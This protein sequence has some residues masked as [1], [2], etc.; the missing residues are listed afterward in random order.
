MT[1]MKRFTFFLAI[2]LVLFALA[3]RVSAADADAVG[4]RLALVVG[5]DNYRDS[6]AKLFRARADAAAM[7]SSLRELGFEVDV[8]AEVRSYSTKMHSLWMKPRCTSN[9]PYFTSK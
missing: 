9:Y 1:V 2:G 3:G 6:K 7:A 5:N 8:Q 4:K